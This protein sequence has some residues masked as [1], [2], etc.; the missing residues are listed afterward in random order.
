MSERTWL[1]RIAM[2]S[3][4]VL[5]LFMAVAMWPITLFLSVVGLVIYGLILWCEKMDSNDE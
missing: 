3:T 2:T 5:G 1:Q 4:I